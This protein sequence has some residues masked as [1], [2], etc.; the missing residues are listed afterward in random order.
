M[1]IVPGNRQTILGTALHLFSQRGYEAVG[2]AEL[3]DE[4][5]ITKPT[6]Y[7]YFGSKRGLLD[8]V[9]AERGTAVRDRVRAASAYDHDVRLGV[10]RIAF[11]FTSS[12]REDSDFARLR[13][14]L[15][16]APPSSESWQ[17]AASMNA[18]LYGC[19]ET[20]FRAAA[21]DHGNMR[22]RSRPY[23]AS[24][25]GTIDTYVGFFLAEQIEL[26]DEVVRGALRQFMYGIFS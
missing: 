3:C 19:V 8:A 20:F 14:A 7:H 15:A 11:A 22:G 5:G 2:V 18:E 25:I 17:A 13:L 12:A 1:E 10:E 6:L 24:F 4:S 16:F 21:D 26:T 9:V 23:A